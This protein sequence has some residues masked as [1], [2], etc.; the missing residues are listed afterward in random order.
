MNY[1]Y[2]NIINFLIV[3]LLLTQGQSL[4]F[5]CNHA[6]QIQCG[7]GLCANYH[8]VHNK[9]AQQTLTCGPTQYFDNSTNICQDCL[10]LNSS[11]CSASCSK[12]H[13][14][15]TAST[16]FTLS[17]IVS[18]C[19]SCEDAFGMGCIS[20]STISCSACDSYSILNTTTGNCMGSIC[21]QLAHCYLCASPTTC[22]L[23]LQGYD[24]NLSTFLCEFSIK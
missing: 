19:S 18:G 15:N 10:H 16:I 5:D 17:N 9:C 24:L 7:I 23:C 12:Y 14:F 11:D 2:W 6:N 3:I 21:T 1:S 13:F 20:C 4:G 8:F 22:K